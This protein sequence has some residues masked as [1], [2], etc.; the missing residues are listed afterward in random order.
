MCFKLLISPDSGR[1]RA[2]FEGPLYSRFVPRLCKNRSSSPCRRFTGRPADKFS[3][4]LRINFA[5]PPT[6]KK[7]VLRLY[8][9]NEPLGAQDVHHSGQIVGQY[10]QAHLRT[11]VGQ[12]FHKKVSRP[13]P[14]FERRIGVLNRLPS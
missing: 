10:M 11:D 14:H 13:H 3:I 6:Q 7:G 4:D 8:R 2:S 1:K 12:P 5:S 9:L